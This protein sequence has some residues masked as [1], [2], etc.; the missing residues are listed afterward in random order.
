MSKSILS[1]LIVA[2]AIAGCK[3]EPAVPKEIKQYTI[4]QLYNNKSISG[5]A[6]NADESK[7]LVDANISGIINLYELGIADTAMKPLT[8]SVK[9]SLFAVDYLPG[10]N[11]FLFSADQGGNENSHIYLQSPGDTS[12]KDITPWPNSANSMYGWNANKTAMYV[13]SNRRDP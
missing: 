7:I 10:T 1:V 5:A 8:H 2:L 11:K 13:S 4:E 12:A 3:N 6:F 9:E